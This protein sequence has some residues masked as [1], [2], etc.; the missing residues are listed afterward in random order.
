MQEGFFQGV[1]FLLVDG[2]EVVGL[3]ADVVKCSGKF[4]LNFV[5]RYRH[6]EGGK[7]LLIDVIDVRTTTT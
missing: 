4:D 2:G 3:F 7:L 6:E 1:E 5:G